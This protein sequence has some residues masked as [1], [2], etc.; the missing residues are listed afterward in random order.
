M[1]KILITGASGTVGK[2]TLKQLC[3]LSEKA[4]ITIFDRGSKK[5][6]QFFSKLKTKFNIVYG[7]ISNKK[8]IE[9]AC[10][11][12]DIVIHL[13]AIIPPLADDE[14]ELAKNVNII[15]TKNLVESI[16]KFSPNA[17][18]IYAS[19]ISVYGDRNN[20]P[21]IKVTDDLKA[22]SRDEY[23]ITKIAAEKLIANSKLNW[24]IFR[25]TA[26]MGV[27]NLKP[28][29][30][31]FHMPLHTK[32][33][34]ST[35]KD[36]AKAFIYAM[37]HLDKLNKNIYNV[38]GGENCRIEYKDFL[39]RSFDILGLGALDFPEKT[40]A[41]KNFHCGMYEDGHILDEM[42]KF[43][44]DTIEDYFKQLKK[45]TPSAQR[46]ATSLLKKVIKQNL[47][48]QSEPLAAVLSNNKIDLEHYF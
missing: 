44:E 24:T 45:A 38:S 21:W 5:A 18:L 19:S 42:L 47:Q 17:F 25:L 3:E 35:P 36:A 16:E 48:K 1:K 8:D 41:E 11:N 4:E 46:I 34:I 20:N 32:L 7:D 13:A 39:S 12:K 9:E 30:T 26:I 33:E 23:A 31:M 2:E 10:K 14:P 40:F 43:R 28:C 29:R 22:S 15:G 37:N 6:A 27:D